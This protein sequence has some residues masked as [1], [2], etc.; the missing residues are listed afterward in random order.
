M[1]L[2]RIPFFWKRAALLLLVAILCVPIVIYVGIRELH[3]SFTDL[4]ANP[5]EWTFL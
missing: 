1:K 5:D 4:W 3:E 2:L